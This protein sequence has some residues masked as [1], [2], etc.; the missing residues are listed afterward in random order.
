MIIPAALSHKYMT[1]MKGKKK[2]IDSLEEASL[3]INHQIYV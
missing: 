2:K 1:K 3:K